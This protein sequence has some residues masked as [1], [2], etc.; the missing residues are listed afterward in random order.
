MKNYDQYYKM[1][2]PNIIMRVKKNIANLSEK[3]HKKNVSVIPNSTKRFQRL[4]FI[5]RVT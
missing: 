5:I 2:L 1:L 3:K 4:Y